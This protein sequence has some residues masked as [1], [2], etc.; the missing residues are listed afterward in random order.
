MK[1]QT[2]FHKIII[3]IP[4]HLNQANCQINY[5]INILKIN[6]SKKTNNLI[7]Y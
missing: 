3:K 7:N 4:K 2:E 6:S 1:I 5:N